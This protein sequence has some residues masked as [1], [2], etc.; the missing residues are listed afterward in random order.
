[1]FANRK[2]PPFLPYPLSSFA[3]FSNS[4]AL[5]RP[6]GNIISAPA[7]IYNLDLFITASNPS[8][9]LASVLAHIT[10]SPFE[11]YFD[12]STHIAT[13]LAKS[14]AEINDL[15]SKCPHLLGKT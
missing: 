1:M 4:S 7:S 2:G 10:N 11:H 8:T 5:S 6:S 3:T 9:D 15:P 13:F 14:S 12:A